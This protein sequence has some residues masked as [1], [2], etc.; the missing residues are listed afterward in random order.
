MWKKYNKNS[1]KHKLHHS[2][3]HGESR[4]VPLTTA[5]KVDAYRERKVL[6]RL[7]QHTNG[8]AVLRNT[9]DITTMDYN[10]RDATR[11]HQGNVP[12]PKMVS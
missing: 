4:K 10:G 11:R 8:T 9:D 7:N 5:E 1:K 3:E 2:P 12:K 6:R